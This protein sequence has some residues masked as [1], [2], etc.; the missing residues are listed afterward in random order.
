MGK[1]RPKIAVSVG[2]LALLGAAG[3]SMPGDWFVATVLMVFEEEIAAAH[4][5]SGQSDP[6]RQ[7][8]PITHI[9]AVGSYSDLRAYQD[10]C[11]E[12]IGDLRK[13]VDAAGDALVIARATVW[14]KLDEIATETPVTSK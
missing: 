5:P 8:L 3:V 6:Q 4:T 2:D 9:R 13:T 11:R 10:K 14:A 7:F 1:K 12:I